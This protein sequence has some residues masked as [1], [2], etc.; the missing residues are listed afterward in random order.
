MSIIVTINSHKD[1]QKFI[2]RLFF[3]KYYKFTKFELKGKYQ[4]EELKNIIKALNIKKRRPR[5]EYIYDEIVKEIDKYYSKDLGD[6]KNDQC[7]Y[8]RRRTDNAK[9]W[10]CYNC[11][12]VKPGTGCPTTNISCKL[13]YCKPIQKK[14]KMLKLKEIPI[15]K[16]LSVFQRFILIFSCYSTKE[17]II[18]DLYYGIILW[19]LRCIKKGIKSTFNLK[20]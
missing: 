19:Y 15:S 2:K 5:L 3:Y 7:F 11:H 14:V 9:Y 20:M 1:Y 12:L 13:V 16:M 10:C 6:F 17:Q 4:N 18:N 8:Q